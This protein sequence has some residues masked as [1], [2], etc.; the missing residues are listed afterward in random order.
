MVS[1]ADRFRLDDFF[2]FTILVGGHTNE[3]EKL[4]QV[5]A[6]TGTDDVSTSLTTHHVTDPPP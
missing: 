1:Q 6:I 2:S 3:D 5:I 4:G